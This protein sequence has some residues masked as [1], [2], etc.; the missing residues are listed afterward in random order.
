M[1]RSSRAP[2]RRSE[3]KTSVHSSKGRLGDQDGA[4]LVALAEDLKEEFRAGGGQ[5]H[6]ALFVDD[7][8]AEAGQLPQQVEQPFLSRASISSWTRAAAVV[9]P[10]DIPRWQAAKP[11]P[12][13]WRPSTS[14]SP[15]PLSGA[16]P[17]MAT[18]SPPSGLPYGAQRLWKH[19]FPNQD[20]GPMPETATLVAET[21]ASPSKHPFH[22]DRPLASH[23]S[24]DLPP[25]VRSTMPHETTVRWKAPRRGGLIRPRDN[26]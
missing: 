7:Q 3:P 16:P 24:R 12:R 13:N 10:T 25:S 14:V 23:L 5:G 17:S 9:K 18:D 20:P 6:E 2:V 15:I 19:R 1:S 11:S 26:I 21:P 4:P 22:A 8:Q